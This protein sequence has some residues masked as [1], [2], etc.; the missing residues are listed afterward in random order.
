MLCIYLFPFCT[1]ANCFR[2]TN[3][4]PHGGLGPQYLGTYSFLQAPESEIS[5]AHFIEKH[6]NSGSRSSI[7][8]EE[9]TEMSMCNRDSSSIL[10]QSLVALPGSQGDNIVHTTSP[11]VSAIGSTSPCHDI[12]SPKYFPCEKEEV[13]QKAQGQ[14]GLFGSGN[15]CSTVQ[16]CAKA[17]DDTTYDHLTSCSASSAATPTSPHKLDQETKSYDRLAKKSP[18]SE[19]PHAYA[20]VHLGKVVK[21][22]VT[23]RDQPLPV[24][25][26]EEQSG[27]ILQIAALGT[28]EIDPEIVLVLRSQ[29]ER[30]PAGTYD[31]DTSHGKQT[32]QYDHLE[33]VKL[34][35]REEEH[36]WKNN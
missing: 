29:N 35:T 14:H 16:K 3:V 2:V 28:Y 27:E 32:D 13:E 1:F 22:D 36:N 31:E 10:M 23:S 20:T 33:C 21:K 19:S 6:V 34:E 25:L 24:S 30:Q 11:F 26:S 4:I 17:I 9:A 5:S 18:N 15:H 8:E 12:Q 7:G